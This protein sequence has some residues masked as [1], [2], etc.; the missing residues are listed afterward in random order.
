M[1]LI[2]CPECGKEVSDASSKC[3]HCGYTFNKVANI[4][5]RREIEVLVHRKQKSKTLG[6]VLIVIS[7]F[8]MWPLL[9]IGIILVASVGRNNSLATNLIDYDPN[10]NKVILHTIKGFDIS[11]SPKN[12]EN[13]V[14]KSFEIVKVK[15]S[16][17]EK[18][19]KLGCADGYEV[20]KANSII[21]ELKR[22]GY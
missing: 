13:L 7:F 15:I 16:D 12:V 17:N 11:V 18:Y 1:S 4:D 14:M 8:Y 19:I 9:I 22:R 20:I 10:I 21:N 3:V 6:I 2:T 5:E